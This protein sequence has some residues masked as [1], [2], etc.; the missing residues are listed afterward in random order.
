MGQEQEEKVK[1]ATMYL[2]IVNKC[3]FKKEYVYMSV[4]VHICKHGCLFLVHKELIAPSLPL[5]YAQILSVLDQI[6][7]LKA[8]K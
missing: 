5:F 4:C 1:T 6:S 2:Q 7:N 3:F 8:L